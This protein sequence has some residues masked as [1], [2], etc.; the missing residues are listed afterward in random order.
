[1]TSMSIVQFHDDKHPDSWQVNDANM[2]TIQILMKAGW[3]PAIN[4]FGPPVLVTENQELALA[5]A[6]AYGI[7]IE[8]V[9]N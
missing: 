1:M 3:R 8:L 9:N 7:T 4:F 6:R 5:A 2:P